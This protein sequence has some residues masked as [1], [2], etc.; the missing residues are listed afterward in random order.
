MGRLLT[1]A[2]FEI[3]QYAAGLVDLAL[4]RHCAVT[5]A[6]LG[7][8]D[9]GPVHPDV[10]NELEITGADYC[11]RCGAPQGLGVGIT[12]DCKACVRYKAGFGTREIVAVGK[13]E[14]VLADM[15]LAL[16]FAGERQVAKPLAVALAG[17]LGTRLLEDK[18]D[19][20][21]PVP[22]SA[23]RRLGRGYNQAEEIARHVSRLTGIPWVDA[24]RRLRDTPRQA[25]LSPAQ[26]RANVKDAFAVRPR[27]K[28]KGARVLLVDDVMT[29]GAT[30]AAAARTLKRGGAKA[31]Y[32]GIA[33]RSMGKV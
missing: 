11:R 30:L 1:S 33:A 26:R 16:K 19:V 22:L 21:V 29:T 17:M 27:I 2:L 4:P 13:Y 8:D 32:G 15:C 23:L 10:L 3:R 6:A 5:G 18:I 14:G 31:V 28:I 20:I 24:L 7:P 25:M 12:T 9:S